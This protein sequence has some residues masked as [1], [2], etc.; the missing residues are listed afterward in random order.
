VVLAHLFSSAP[1]RR[2]VFKASGHDFKAAGQPGFVAGAGGPVTYIIRSDTLPEPA[3]LALLGMGLAG[4]G[5]ARR[6]LH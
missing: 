4:L 1:A 5:F 2:N 6:K 3:T